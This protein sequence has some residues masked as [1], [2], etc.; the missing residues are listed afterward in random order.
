[1]V[2]PEAIEIP[3]FRI[4]AGGTGTIYA[5]LMDWD[6]VSPISNTPYTIFDVDGE[7]LTGTTD[8]EGILRHDDVPLGYY[9]LS[10]NEEET[11]VFTAIEPEEPAIVRLLWTD[12]PE[13]DEEE[14]SE[15][16]RNDEWE[17]YCRS[18]NTEDEQTDEE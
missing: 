5:K 9:I 18:L 7:E 17:D 4:E 1:M 14:N 6:E 10:A 13:T 2:E 3:D 16:G 11:T 15:D 12:P 8:S